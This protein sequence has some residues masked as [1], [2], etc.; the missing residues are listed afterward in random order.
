MYYL[1]IHAL[2]LIRGGAE[3]E[4]AVQRFNRLKCEA[5]E[6]WE[7]VNG[8]KNEAAAGSD[9]KKSPAAAGDINSVGA[10]FVVWGD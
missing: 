5:S 3:P 1:P 6:L 4:T 10:K 8:M 9:R 7:E 2:R